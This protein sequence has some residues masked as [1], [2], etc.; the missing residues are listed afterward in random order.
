MAIAVSIL[1]GTIVG[2]PSLRLSG[3]YLAVGTLAL[4]YAGQQ[5]LYN[6]DDVTGGGFG[7]SVGRIQIGNRLYTLVD[8]TFL[9]LGVSF[10]L[11]SNLLRGRTGRARTEG[12]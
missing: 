10:V 1:V 5:L 9:L 3:L 11:V 7:Q 4:G 2:L 6:W 12:G 8:A